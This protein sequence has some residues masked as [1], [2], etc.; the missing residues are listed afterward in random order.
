L[1]EKGGTPTTLTSLT[2][3]GE[4]YS[5]HLADFF[6]TT[7]LPANGTL[8]AAL[9]ASGFD[10]LPAD[11]VFAFSGVDPDGD[12]WTQKLTI[13]FMPEQISAAMVLTSAPAAEVQN[14]KG[15]PNCTANHP[16]Y[17][18]LNLEER[19]GYAVKLTKFYAGQN[20]FSNNIS[21]WFGSDRLA[22]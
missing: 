12:K 9:G 21:N 8:T 1:T 2:I 15:D 6:G 5:D 4:D 13:T 3:D 19:N 14:P 16:F 10:T 20:D 17:Q 7:N 22:A 11:I 18:E